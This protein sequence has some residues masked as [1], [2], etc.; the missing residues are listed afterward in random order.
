MVVCSNNAHG[1][2]HFLFY[3]ARF[4]WIHPPTSIGVLRKFFYNILKILFLLSDTCAR[5]HDAQTTKKDDDTRKKAV[6]P[7]FSKKNKKCLTLKLQVYSILLLHSFLIIEVALILW[8]IGKIT[9]IIVNQHS[10]RTR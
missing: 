4:S 5:V 10:S 8:I 1:A 7:K 6:L 9:A 2:Q 3:F